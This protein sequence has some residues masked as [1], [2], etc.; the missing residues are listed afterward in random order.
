MK[1]LWLY[2]QV[3]L[4]LQHHGDDFGMT[5][6]FTQCF[7]DRIL[8]N[9]QDGL[10]QTPNFKFKEFQTLPSPNPRPQLALSNCPQFIITL[11]ALMLK[12][13][14]LVTAFPD[15]PSS[16]KERERNSTEN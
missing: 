6:F 5:D 1:T 4:V 13:R 9:K 15:P 7:D 14:C 2:V 10:R 3:Q 11:G 12:N 16:P 8:T